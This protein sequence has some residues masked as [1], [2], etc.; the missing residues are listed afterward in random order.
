MPLDCEGGTRAGMGS[1]R[2]RRERRDDGAIR[3]ARAGHYLVMAWSI[4]EMGNRI[5]P[6][7]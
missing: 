5:E 2:G 7:Q 4:H 6:S 3:C 1:R